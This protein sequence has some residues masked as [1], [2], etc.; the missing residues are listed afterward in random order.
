[1][2]GVDEVG[3]GCWAGPLLVVAARANGKLPTGLTDSKLLNKKQRESIFENLK[4]SVEFGE[5][6]VSAVEIDAVGLAAALKLGISRALENL[7]VEFI[8]KIVFD[9]SVN[10]VDP[11]FI[12]SKCEIDADLSIPI[13]SAASIYA[14]V[15][16]DNFMNKLSLKYPRY[17]F[18]NHVGYGTKMHNLALQDLGIITGV[19]RTS[20]KPIKAFIQK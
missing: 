7:K 20:F 6:W 3:R 5:G 14:K 4:Y 1:M 19:H 18:E 15:T 13:V 12:N 17:G 11:K 2:V 16:R 10:Y 8:E 9:G